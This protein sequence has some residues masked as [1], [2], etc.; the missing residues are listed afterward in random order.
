MRRDRPIFHFSSYLYLNLIDFH[1]AVNFPHKN[2]EKKIQLGNGKSNQNNCHSPCSSVTHCATEDAQT[3]TKD[4][5]VAEI[6]SG[7]EQPVHSNKV[8]ELDIY[9]RYPVIK[10][11]LLCFE[12]EIV[13]R[14]EE[15]VSCCG[16]CGHK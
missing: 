2:T 1:C 8:K 12:E 4:S 7:L 10:L 9:N 6:E 14:V 5:H 3:Q 16:T 13:K 11:N 15:D